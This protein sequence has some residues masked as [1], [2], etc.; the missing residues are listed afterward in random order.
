MFGSLP[1][2]GRIGVSRSIL[3]SGLLS[4]GGAAQTNMSLRARAPDRVRMRESRRCVRV[5][6][7]GALRLVLRW[8]PISQR[9]RPYRRAG[10]VSRRFC[11]A[12]PNPSSL[13]CGTP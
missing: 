12:V 2:C 4:S 3:C 11:R 8:L 1:I 10:Y 13:V 9:G 7:A 6:I 5:C